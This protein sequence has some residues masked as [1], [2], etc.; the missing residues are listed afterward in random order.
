MGSYH[1]TCSRA[2]GDVITADFKPHRR[3]LSSLP[4]SLRDPTKSPEDALMFR[5]DN[6][7]SNAGEGWNNKDVNVAR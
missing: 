1:R 6:G 5:A 2:I 4:A 7:T 3:A